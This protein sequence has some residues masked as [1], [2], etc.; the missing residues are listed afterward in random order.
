[1]KHSITLAGHRTS[2]SLEPVF[3]DAL[4]ALADKRGLS[5]ASLVGA[6]DEARATDADPK[7]AQSSQSLSS[8]I[9]VAVMQAAL[10][11]E[12]ALSDLAS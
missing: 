7:G 4:K 3:W 9:R 11:G 8:Y 10:E 1:M 5:V 12:I 2:L 6:I